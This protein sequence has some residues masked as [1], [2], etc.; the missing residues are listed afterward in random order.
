MKNRILVSVALLFL[1][2]GAQAQDLMKYGIMPGMVASA[3]TAKDVPYLSAKE[4]EIMMIMN[5]VRMY[6]QAFVAIVENEYRGN[7]SS[8]YYTSLIATL[9]RSPSSRPLQP[10]PTVTRASRYH[11]L[12][13]GTTGRTGHISTNGDSGIQRVSKVMNRSIAAWAEN[14]SYG[15]DN[16]KEIIIQLLVD[17]G[18]PSLGHRE[19]ILE[20]RY[21]HAGVAFEPHK[22]YRNNSVVDFV[23][24]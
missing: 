7:K 21:T 17:E 22:A 10:H 15:Y 18:I 13:M 20:P 12:D 3:N 6:P 23:Q 16:P 2:L 11:A 4:K 24:L 5:L 9:K 1:G 8:R 19:N 14:C